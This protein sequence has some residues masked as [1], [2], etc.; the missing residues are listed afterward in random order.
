MSR[1]TATVE[2]ARHLALVA[3]LAAALWPAAVS[4]GPQDQTESGRLEQELAETRRSFEATRERLRE[5][6]RELGEARQEAAEWEG[7]YREAAEGGS[8][9]ANVSDELAAAR[10]RVAELSARLAE[11]EA[12]LERCRQDLAERTAPAAAPSAAPAAADRVRVRAPVA[13]R[14]SPPE[15][16]PVPVPPPDTRQPQPPMQDEPVPADPLVAE[17][18]RPSVAEATAAV[19]AGAAAWS[20]QQPGDYLSFYSRR[21]QPAD[22]L[23]RTAWQELRRE[24][25]LRP[26]FITVGLSQL[27]VEVEAPDRVVASFVQTYDS[28]VFQDEVRKRLVLVLEDGAWRILEEMAAP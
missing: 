11:A 6:T 26:R 1:R 10:E 28:D 21:F 5:A 7:R 15:L 19:Q 9:T 3:A 12:E 8:F 20:G 25:L 23:S 17:D 16:V 14:Q 22:G 2:T 27:E 13:L 18:D 4:A 24:R